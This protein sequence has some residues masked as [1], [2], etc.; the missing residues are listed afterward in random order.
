M[1]I[2][3]A[4]TFLEVVSTGSFVVASDRLHV[5]QTAVSARIR[6]LE[7]QLGRRLFVRNKAGARLTPAGER[8]RRYA[9]TLVQV[10]ERARQQVALPAGRADIVS[11]GGEVS[12]WSP[13]LAEW[14]VWMRQNCPDIALKAEIDLPE[15]LLDRLQDGSLDLAVLYSPPLRPDLVTELLSEEKLVM[16]TTSSGEQFAAA[17]YIHVDWGT[18]FNTSLQAAFPQLSAPSV[19]ISLG[20]VAISYMLAVGGT[21]YFRLSV[22]QPYLDDG[23]LHRMRQ[24]PEFSYSIYAVYSNRG[25]GDLLNRVRKGLSACI[26][27]REE[28]KRP[29]VRTARSGPEK[30]RRRA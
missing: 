4:R 18:A 1:D 24:A 15:R 20:P 30:K 25:D 22:V 19:S 17:D 16:V 11:I 14:L 3:L 12:L 21:G 28:E 7:E 29:R 23:H 2:T 5:T 13:L 26:A 8:F 27:P 6:T 9:M 10:W